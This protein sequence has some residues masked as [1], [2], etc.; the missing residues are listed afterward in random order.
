M[1]L[2]KANRIYLGVPV[3]WC[4]VLAVARFDGVLGFLGHW[5][6]LLSY[7][8]FVFLVV[9]GILRLRRHHVY[10]PRWFFWI[11]MVLPVVVLIH[12]HAG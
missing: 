10:W 2:A 6:A 8:V 7:V 3:L 11:G 4:G 9:Y 1:L 5:A 12:H